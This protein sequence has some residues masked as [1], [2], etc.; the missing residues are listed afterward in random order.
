MADV[1]VGDEIEVTLP[2]G[3]PFAASPQEATFIAELSEKYTTEFAFVSSSDLQDLDRVVIFEMLVARWGR[4]LSRRADDRD[5]PIDEKTIREGI[6]STSTELR[7]LKKLLGIDKV[8]RDKAKGEGSVP[9]YLANLMERAKAFGVHREHQLDKALELTHQL[10]AL[11]LLY[12]NCNDDERR[13]LHVTQSDLI[14]WIE[15]VF[16][17]EFETIDQYFR[18]HEQKFWVRD[19]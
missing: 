18:A 13:N 17:V 5:N 1:E 15:E 4:W 14:E 2:S 11:V 12:R 8:A 6:G 7:Q 16:L 3:A 19:L 10:G 9:H